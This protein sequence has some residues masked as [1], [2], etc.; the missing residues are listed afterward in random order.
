MAGMIVGFAV[1]EAVGILLL[2]VGILIWKKEKITLLHDYHYNKVRDSDRKAFCALSGK[3]ASLIGAG[4]CASGILL[5]VTESVKSMIVF[6]VCFFA[7]L[8]MM[9]RAGMK[10]NR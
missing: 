4:I 6:A 10:Y 8:F 2:A 3:G 5:A 1:M 9:I 7:G